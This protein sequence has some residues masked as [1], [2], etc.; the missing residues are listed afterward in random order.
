M[1]HPVTHLYYT[2]P[3]GTLWPTCTTLTH[4]APCDPPVYT[5]PWGTLWPTCTTLY[6]SDTS[7]TRAHF[8]FHIF[9]SA[10]C[11]HFSSC[12]AYKCDTSDDGA[13]QF[14]RRAHRGVIQTALTTYEN[15]EMCQQIDVG[16]PKW[17]QWTAEASSKVHKHSAPVA[18]PWNFFRR[19]WHQEI[20][21][22]GCSTN[23]VDD[24]G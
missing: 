24:R 2:D 23:L 8:Q 4:E 19:G 6:N 10:T 14:E 15:S 5:D 7:N 16:L 12:L 9:T 1:R 11:F 3:W 13:T 21:R 18:Y 17:V 22:G 20:F